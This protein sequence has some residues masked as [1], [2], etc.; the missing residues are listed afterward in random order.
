VKTQRNT[1]FFFHFIFFIFIGFFVYQAE[2]ICFSVPQ[3]T[4][5]NDLSQ[6]GEIQNPESRPFLVIEGNSFSPTFSE[7]H[8]LTNVSILANRVIP[9]N[10]NFRNVSFIPSL[11]N[12]DSPIPIFIK[13]HALLN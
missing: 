6:N 10:F 5:K 11:I 7:Y 9:I 12:F 3:S 2:S 8:R 1:G 13:G 4:T